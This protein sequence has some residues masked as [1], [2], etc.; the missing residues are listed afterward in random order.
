MPELTKEEKATQEAR[1]AA[2]GKIAEDI[3]SIK[4][5]Q[6]KLFDKQNREYEEFKAELA[7]TVA[8]GRTENTEKVTRLQEQVLGRQEAIDNMTK[9]LETL[10]KRL[11]DLEVQSQR[12][13]KGTTDPKDRETKQTQ[14]IE[15]KRQQLAVTGKL[16]FDSPVEDLASVEELAAYEP[17]FA[18]YLRKD[19]RA[20]TPDQFKALSVGSD[21]DG[22]YLVKPQMSARIVEI[23][24]E[25][26]PIRDLASVETI[27]TE[28]L[29]IKAET[30]LAGGGW[31]G[32]TDAGGETT[33]P[34]IDIINIP[35]HTLIARPRATQKLLE[36][37]STNVEAWL[38]RKL[39]RTFAI[40]E[41]TAFVSGNGVTRPR[42]FLTYPS[43]TAW[44]QVEQVVTGDATNLTT[45]GLIDLLFALKEQYMTRATFLARRSTVRDIMKL[46][47]G[48]GN[49]IWR[50]SFELGQPA[51]LLGQPIRWA[52]DMPA[53]AAGALCIAVADWAEAYQVVDRIGMSVVR[54]PY[55]VKP[56][57]EFY[58]RRRCGGAV[59]NFEAIKLQV[60]HV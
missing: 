45:D 12:L 47:D 58:T 46:K 53:V 29:E 31:Q 50:V 6:A 10:V 21:P 4:D 27:G 20:L 9:Q 38:T 49:Y 3:K 55:T 34:T 41:A 48:D 36:D 19:D 35:T 52:A 18:R 33:T 1:E 28:S 14:A 30:D 43:G 23:I 60:V 2:L 15:F 42:G 22:G 24:H 56:F 17:A 32:E 54:D 51:N 57:V 7:S 13:G 26:S 39:A 59:V 40:L 5:D 16:K 25:T 11:G 8:A 37:A 44:S